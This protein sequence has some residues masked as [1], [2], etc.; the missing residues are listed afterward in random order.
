[1]G[2]VRGFR[3]TPEEMLANLSRVVAATRPRAA[4]RSPGK[5]GTGSS[6]RNGTSPRAVVQ[7][8]AQA[9]PDPA[10][11]DD[12]GA[13]LLTDKQA[14]AGTAVIAHTSAQRPALQPLVPDG[15]EADEVSRITAGVSGNGG[16]ALNDSGGGARADMSPREKQWLTAPTPRPVRTKPVHAFWE[17]VEPYFKPLGDKELQHC[18]SSQ[19]FDGA[20]PPRP[21]PSMTSVPVRVKRLTVAEN[22]VH[23]GSAARG[24]TSVWQP[25]PQ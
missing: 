6:P 8:Q 4:R 22:G 17:A 11:P 14:A 24:R 16:A 12:P 23:P 25:L 5:R 1:M 7:D 3:K 15:G 19:L 21:P 10:A 20:P 18:V 9:C 2:K 13:G